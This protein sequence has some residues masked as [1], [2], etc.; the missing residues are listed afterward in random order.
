MAILQSVNIAVPQPNPYKETRTTGINKVPQ[1]TPIEVRSPGAKTTGLGSGLVGDHIGDGKHHGGDGQAVYAF[2][3]E[4]LD[5]WQRRL[6]RV[7]PNGY[8]GENL[9]TTGLDV[10]GALLG[11]RWRIGDQ[12]ELEV[13]GPRIP[14]AT[15][16]GWTG[17][18]G[19]LKTFTGLA[20]PGAYLSVVSP[21]FIKAGDAIEI[22]FRPTHE[23][24]VSLSYQALTTRRELLPELLAA[25]HYL[26]DEVRE[27]IREGKV[28]TLG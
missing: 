17:E 9:T 7:L 27:M 4:D 14:C 20:R 19:W 6:D 11:E 12:V 28:F 25:D 3:R 13:T 24:S 23:V 8:F 15:F 22:S 5:H 10:N 26:D 2:E 21:G 18:R 16:R 1:N